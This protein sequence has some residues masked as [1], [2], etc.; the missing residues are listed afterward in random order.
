MDVACALPRLLQQP[1][2]AGE[3]LELTDPSA[4][5]RSTLGSPQASVGLAWCWQ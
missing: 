1:W 3:D 2:Q 5:S 4:S